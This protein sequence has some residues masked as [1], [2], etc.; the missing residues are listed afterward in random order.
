MSDLCTSTDQRHA[1]RVADNAC[2]ID[3]Y[4][5]AKYRVVSPWRGISG[6]KVEGRLCS[7][8]TA[9]SERARMVAWVAME[10]LGYDPSTI[11]WALPQSER[12]SARDMLRQAVKCAG[13]VEIFY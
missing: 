2:R 13:P 4:P 1:L 9:R 7:Y 8:N 5:H 3:A 12:G 10:S 11:A 6:P